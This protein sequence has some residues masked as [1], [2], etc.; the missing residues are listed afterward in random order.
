MTCPFPRQLAAAIAFIAALAAAALFTAPAQAVPATSESVVEL[1]LGKSGS[2]LRSKSLK[3]RRLSPAKL[4]KGILTLKVADV[5]ISS[6]TRAAVVLRGGLKLSAGKKS[7]KLQGL[8]LKVSGRNVSI[9]GKIGK[10][11]MKIVT[12]RTSTNVV[13]A[14]AQSVI[15]PAVSMK[16]TSAAASSIAKQLKL[17][18]RP[19]KSLG[20][21]VSFTKTRVPAAPSTG[22]IVLQDLGG[23]RLARP[24]SAVDV[25]GS[26]LKWWIRDSW[27]RYLPF[28]L[29]VGGATA[30]APIAGTSHAC[31]DNEASV[32]DSYAYN[33]PFQSGW[34]D[35]A[36]STGAMYYTGG[37]RWYFP[38]HGI[39]LTASAVEIEINGGASRVVL[40]I[41]DASEKT[42]KRGPFA[43]LNTA[44]PLS[45]SP[46]IGPGQAGS[47]IK[48][49]ILLDP[50]TSPFGS[51]TTQYESRPGWGCFDLAFTA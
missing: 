3:S 21:F 32:S 43:S 39:D 23:P 41:D 5:T 33:L 11:R 29:P 24:V 44:T 36:S 2:A 26:S 7:V 34:W 28:N 30:D 18:K 15:V 49:T 17:K 12:A 37:V 48:S 50:A 20:K 1:P 35:A 27:I 16:L 46:V 38:E 40:R 19:S 31:I 14:A 10:R 45:G 25:T 47:L 9:T 6:A 4:K 8:L 22:G 51:F 13:N 42:A